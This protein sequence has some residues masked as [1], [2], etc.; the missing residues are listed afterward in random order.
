M[1]EGHLMDAHRVHR[2]IL[3]IIILYVFHVVWL[4][5]CVHN[6]GFWHEISHWNVLFA[7]THAAYGPLFNFAF[8]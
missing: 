2:S 5:L 1:C 7:F 8:P 3:Y 4:Q 6:W